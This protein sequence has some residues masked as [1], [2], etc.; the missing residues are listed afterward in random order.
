MKAIGVIV[1]AKA[2]RKMGPKNLIVTTLVISAALLI[3]FGTTKSLP[4]FL[5]VILV[6]GFLGGGYEKNGGYI[7][8]ENPE[9]IVVDFKMKLFSI[10]RPTSFFITSAR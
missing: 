5:I 10:I 3:V 6:I 4:L 2:V 9:N 1:L 7:R 8:V